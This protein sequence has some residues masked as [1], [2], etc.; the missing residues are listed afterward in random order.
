MKNWKSN[1]FVILLVVFMLVCGFILGKID[2][3]DDNNQDMSGKTI[4]SKEFFSLFVGKYKYE[5]NDREH[6][7]CKSYNNLELKADGT[8]LYNYGDTCGGGWNLQG[9]YSASH[10]KIYLFNDNCNYIV[11]DNECILPNCNNLETL[12]YILIDGEIKIT[13]GNIE[14]IEE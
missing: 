6:T 5:K 12:N 8:Y 11:Q 1:L 7:D 13:I 10:D 9:N 2:F 14:L 3:K 4:S